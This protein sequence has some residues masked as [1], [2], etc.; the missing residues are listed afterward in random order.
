MLQAPLRA[1]LIPL[2]LLGLL[3]LLLLQ[4]SL[5]Q[6]LSRHDSLVLGLDLLSILGQLVAFLGLGPEIVYGKA[7]V[8]VRSEIVHGPDR[9]EQIG[10]EL[11]RRT[12]VSKMSLCRG[13]EEAY[14]EDFEV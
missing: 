5:S 11:F 8:Q 10:A 1:V 13:R 3:S 2:R 14:L 4:E 7:I 6:L 12:R 9:E